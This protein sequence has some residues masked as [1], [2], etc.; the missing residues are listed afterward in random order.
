[1][2]ACRN[3]LRLTKGEYFCACAPT[4]GNRQEQNIGASGHQTEVEECCRKKASGDV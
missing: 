3:G 1:M 4:K 2:K